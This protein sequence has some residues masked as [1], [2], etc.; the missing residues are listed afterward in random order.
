MFNRQQMLVNL[1]ILPFIVGVISGLITNLLWN[2][3]L[4]LALQVS[5]I[6]FIVCFIAFLLSQKL[7]E[8][9]ILGRMKVYTSFKHAYTDVLRSAK[10]STFTNIIAIRGE[11]ILDGESSVYPEIIKDARFRNPAIRILLLN[12][13]SVPMERYLN[14]F[15]SPAETEGY[16]A[17]AKLITGKISEHRKNGANVDAH[18]YNEDPLW[19]LLMTNKHC[20]FIGYTEN[21]RGRLLPLIRVENGNNCFAI[22]L[23]RHFEELWK[24]SIPLA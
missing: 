13:A 20:F 10:G 14:Q 7:S 17:K 8:H 12:P 11:H 21:T 9:R 1:I 4:T 19:K 15:F 6:V 3:P 22:A 2:Q 24:N 18:T 16:K 5:G 23:T